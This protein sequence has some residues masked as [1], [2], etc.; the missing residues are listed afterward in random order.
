MNN[1]RRGALN[2]IFY[3]MLIFDQNRAAICELLS[4]DFLHIQVDNGY[5]NAFSRLGQQHNTAQ[6]WEKC[7]DV[8]FN[9]YVKCVVKY[10]SNCND[11]LILQ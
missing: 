9:A 7:D 2:C 6:Q 1:V 10:S 5:C 3:Q 8:T 11:N 4:F